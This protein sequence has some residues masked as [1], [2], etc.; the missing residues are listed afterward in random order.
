IIQRISLQFG[1]PLVLVLIFFY[2]LKRS[3]VKLNL[4]SSEETLK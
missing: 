2:Y 3:T 1:V 4:N